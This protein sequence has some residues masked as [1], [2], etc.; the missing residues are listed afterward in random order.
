[1]SPSLE[2]HKKAL[3]ETLGLDPQDLGEAE[4][5]LLGFFSTLQKIEQRLIREGEFKSEPLAYD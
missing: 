5:S 4:N 2:L 1:M 3:V